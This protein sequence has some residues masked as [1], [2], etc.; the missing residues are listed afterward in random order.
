L[1][2]KKRH[3]SGENSSYLPSPI[4]VKLSGINFQEKHL[5]G[6]FFVPIYLMMGNDA[7]S[8][9]VKVKSSDFCLFQQESI[10]ITI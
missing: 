1:A 8:M 7:F 9:K 2:V 5:R 3:L 4:G 10:I 6:A